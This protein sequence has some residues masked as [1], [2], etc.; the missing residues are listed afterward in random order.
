MTT[1]APNAA[2]NFGLAEHPVHA[3]RYARADEF[4]EVVTK[5]WDSWEDEALSPTRSG[6]L[7]RHRPD[8]LDRPRRTAL[9][10]RADRS[11]PPRS[12]QG[13]PVYVQAGSSEDGR[14]VRRALGRGDLHRAPD[15]RRTPRSSTP[16][17]R[18]GPAERAQSRPDARCS[19]GSARSS[20]P[21]R[22]EARGA[23]RGVQ[24][25][26]PAGVSLEQ[27]TQ[28]DRRRP[29]RRTTSTG[30]SPASSSTTEESA[31]IGSR[32]QVVLDIVDREQPTI[33]QLLH[34][35]AGAAVTGS[36]SAHRSR[37]PTRCS[38]GDER[39]RRRLQ[40]DAALAD[41]RLRRFV[42]EVVPI[43]RKRGLFGSE[44]TGATLRDHYGLR[45]AGQPVRHHQ[46]RSYSKETA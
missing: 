27:L 33:R 42:E 8:P 43:L 11:T 37:S 19:R 31:G 24:R 15:A 18:S 32:F 23:A 26:H 17:S 22:R 40:R 12:P 6:H 20:G 1:G 21:P 25:P 14:G 28:D 38:S 46:P 4:L 29:L 13:R 30:R 39:G 10:R 34:R 16:T 36:S 2:Q 44:Y 3:D 7:R 5:L 35:L 45:S 41:R 9:L